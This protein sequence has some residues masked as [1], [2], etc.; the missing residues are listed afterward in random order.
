MRRTGSDDHGAA[1]SDQLLPEVV[2]FLEV[3]APGLMPESVRSELLATDGLF[4]TVVL[5]TQGRRSALL[6]ETLLCLAGQEAD[7][8]EVLVVLHDPAADAREQVVRDTQLLAALRP[9]R[10]RV[11]EARGGTRV[12]PITTGL[13]EATGRYAVVLDDDDHVTADWVST[14]RRL[15]LEAPGRVLRGGSGVRENQSLVGPDGGAARVATSGTIPFYCEPWSFERHV[16]ANGTPFHAFAFPVAAVHLLGIA[17][18][19]RLDVV[20]DW[21]LL[22]RMSGALGVHEDLHVTSVYNKGQADSSERLVEQPGWRSAEEPIR[23]RHRDAPR[24]VA[25]APART[26]G[27]SPGPREKL[28][29][30]RRSVAYVY[31]TE[32]ARGVGSR[33]RK[34]IAS[35]DGRTR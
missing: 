18:D 28:E 6:R 1:A 23:A 8:F 35:G 31:S 20:E 4:L 15:W 2:R 34:R 11:L 17:L 30:L 7:D 12:R 22:L 33:I 32:G 29:A 5:R 27:R 19:E 25:G 10:V 13:N 21:D 26:G 9:G 24:L 3:Y 16:A 14:F